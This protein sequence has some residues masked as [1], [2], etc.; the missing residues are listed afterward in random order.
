[1]TVPRVNTNGPELAF[2]RFPALSLLSLTHSLTS[3]GESVAGLESG[4]LHFSEVS[5]A[6]HPA[7]TQV[8]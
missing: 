5:E 3:G 7:P 4:H 8:E 1:M 6:T 2:P